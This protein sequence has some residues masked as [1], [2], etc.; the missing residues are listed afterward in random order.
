MNKNNRALHNFIKGKLNDVATADTDNNFKFG[1]EHLFSYANGTLTLNVNN[2]STLRTET[3]EIVPFTIIA[4][5]GER[6]PLETTK[7]FKHILPIVFTLRYEYLETLE[8]YIEDFADSINS[9]TFDVNGINTAFSVTNVSPTSVE[10]ELDAETWVDVTI[11]V[12]AYQGELMLGND[13]GFTIGGTAYEPLSYTSNMQNEMS[14]KTPQG[15]QYGSS[16]SNGKQHSRAIVLLQDLSEETWIREIEDDI[17][18]TTYSFITTYPFDTPYD[19]QRLMR[20]DRGTATIQNGTSVLL[21]LIFV[22][23]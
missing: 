8:S 15:Q 7:I 13:V 14:Y 3:T 17:L 19:A 9:K 10:K 12:F 20:L 6:I 23:A 18:N 16:K 21:E 1:A 5:D 22:D 11:T 2:E 4:F